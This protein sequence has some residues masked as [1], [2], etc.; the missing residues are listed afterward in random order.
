MKQQFLPRF[1]PASRATHLR[2]EIYEIKQSNGESL[3]E[4]WERFKVL[5]A[6][7][8][9]H[10]FT[11]SL[12]IQYFYEGLSG[13]DRCMVDA[14][15]GGALID[16]TLKKAQHLISTM[17]KNYRQYG[18]HTDRGVSMINEVNTNNLAEKLSELTIFVHQMA[19]E[20]RQETRVCGICSNSGHPTD[21]CPSLQE[22]VMPDMNAVGGFPGQP[23]RKYDSFSN[24]Y[25][26]GWRNHLNFSY[27]NQGEQP[28]PRSQLFN[29][30]LLTPAQA[31]SQT[32]NSELQDTRTCLNHLGNQI[33]Q[34][35]TS[36]S[37]LA[38]QSSG[39]L[40]SQTEANPREN[41][42]AMTLQS[43]N[44]L[45]PVEPTSTKAKEGGKSLDNTDSHTDKVDS[46]FIPPT[47]SNTCALSFPY[48]MSKSKED[49]H[50][51]PILD[52]FKK[53]ADR[54]NVSPMGLLE[55]VLV[56]MGTEGLNNPASI[57][58]GRPFMKIA[59][60]KIGV[61]EGTLSVEFDGKIVKFKISEAMK[62]PNELQALYQID[63]VDS[64]VHDVLKEEL[65]G[66]ELDLIMDLDEDDECVEFIGEVVTPS[67]SFG[68]NHTTSQTNSL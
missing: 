17:A 1:F 67:Q 4:Y 57:L 51:R 56:K 18:Y 66:T 38:A 14:A 45:Q 50:E 26:P 28:R 65:V 37:Q 9:H 68:T 64:V 40:P 35:A 21:E 61:D 31:P 43:R 25:N 46:N 36:F 32:P 19:A 59:K 54:S 48:R 42:S 20:Q 8:P 30:P 53:L 63:V 13:M 29:R 62:Y 55:N 16:K 47:S 34:L 11:E 5:V 7:Y 41:V 58:L 39:K 10:Q 60:T 3:Y 22:G 15:S 24:F 44:E 33:S 12:L 2:K 52:T 6:S 49:E 23:Q 27:R